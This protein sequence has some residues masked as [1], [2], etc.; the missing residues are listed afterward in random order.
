MTTESWKRTTGYF[1]LAL[2]VATLAYDLAA[3]RAAGYEASVS[4]FVVNLTKDWPIVPFLAGV[5]AG[6][7]WFPA[8]KDKKK[9]EAK[10]HV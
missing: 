4:R 1:V 8:A 2:V 5:V 7:L 6:H 10:T 3:V 9:K